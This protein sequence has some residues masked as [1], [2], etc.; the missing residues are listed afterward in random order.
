MA[1]YGHKQG[2]ARATRSSKS[3]PHR[4]NG[5]YRASRACRCSCEER[6]LLHAASLL[7]ESCRFDGKSIMYHKLQRPIDLIMWRH[8]HLRRASKS[9]ENDFSGSN[10]VRSMHRWDVQRLSGC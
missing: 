1:V 6:T 9:R 3:P 10:V 5:I 7:E 8:V 2:F 4:L